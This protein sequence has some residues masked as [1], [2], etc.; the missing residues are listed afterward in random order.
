M[1]CEGTLSNRAGLWGHE[2]K[3]EVNAVKSHGGAVVLLHRC[4]MACAFLHNI[5]INNGDILEPEESGD[6]GEEAPV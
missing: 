4:L 1:P 2:G 5:C 3:V 6:E